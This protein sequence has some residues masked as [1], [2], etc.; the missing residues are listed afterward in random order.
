MNIQAI[1]C[2]SCYAPLNL[3]LSRSG[4]CTCEYCGTQH[5]LTQEL[6]VKVN[7]NDRMFGVKLRKV[8]QRNFSL[9]ELEEIVSYMSGDSRLVVYSFDWDC[10][11]HSTLNLATMELIGWLNRRGYLDVLVE[12]AIKERPLIITELL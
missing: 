2:Q 11:R 9:R 10:I 5:N 3:E 1:N 8:L 6:M 12:Y 7:Y 4:I